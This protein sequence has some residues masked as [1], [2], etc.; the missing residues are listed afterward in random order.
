MSE[1]N[2]WELIRVEQQNSF[3]GEKVPLLQALD[4]QYNIR[5]GQRQIW[6]EITDV[7]LLWMV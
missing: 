7:L 1:R 5:L 4:E 3:R 6:N 2:Q